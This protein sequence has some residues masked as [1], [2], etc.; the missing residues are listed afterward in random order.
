LFLHGLRR[1]GDFGVF[2]RV[3]RR[4]FFWK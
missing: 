4:P 2:G 1:L 3:L